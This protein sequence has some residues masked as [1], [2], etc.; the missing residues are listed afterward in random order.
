M[1]GAVLLYW[2]AFPIVPFLDIP[3]KLIVIPVMAV[4]GEVLF[5]FTVAL[6]GKEY[7]GQMKTWIRKKVFRR[8]DDH[9]LL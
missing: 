8:H 3:N 4:M 9:A 7:W 5:I 2:V 1:L 6:L